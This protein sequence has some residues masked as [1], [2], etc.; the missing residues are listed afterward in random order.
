MRKVSVVG[1]PGSGKSTMAAE[2]AGR[3]GVPHVE[4]DGLFHQPGWQ[5]AAADDFQA[6]VADA[7]AGDGWVIDGNYSAVQETIWQH[8]DTVI[9]YD[10]PRRQVM[11]QVIWRTLRRMAYRVELWNGN[12]ERWSNLFSRDPENSIIVWAWQKHPYYRRRYR[13]AMVDPRWSRLRF[14]RVTSHTQARR[15]LH[16]L[17]R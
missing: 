8:A 3:L 11:R 6:S 17:D 9:W 15:L 2:L 1:G 4:L 12:R 14:V 16:D 13:A 5:P 10:L 7:I